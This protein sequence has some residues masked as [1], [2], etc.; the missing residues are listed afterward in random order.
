MTVNQWGR[1]KEDQDMGKYE[2]VQK[3]NSNML[4]LA[5]L[6]ATQG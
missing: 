5:K 6:R 2:E 3:F 4:V 1:E